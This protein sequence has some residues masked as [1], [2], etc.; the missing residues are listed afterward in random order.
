[1]LAVYYQVIVELAVL[2]V[3]DQEIVELAVLVIYNRLGYKVLVC[4]QFMIKK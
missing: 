2:A 4:L 1:M 3:Y